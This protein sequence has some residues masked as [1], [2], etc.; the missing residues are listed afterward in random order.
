MTASTLILWTGVICTLAIFSLL[1]KENPVYRFFEHLF[2]GVATGYT[3]AQTWTDILKPKLWVG[4]V[5]DPAAGD[6]GGRWWMAVA[7]MI[8]LMYYAIYFRRFSWMSRLLIGIMMGFGAGLAFQG[9][10]TNYGP[11]VAA[12]FTPLLPGGQADLTL[13]KLLNNWVMFFT[14]VAVMTYFFFAFEQQN[15]AVQNTAKVGRWLLMISFGA[16]FG[17]TVM[18]RMALAAG[19]LGFLIDFFRHPMGGG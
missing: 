3:L 12:A 15:K 2:I 14:L 11:Q 19:R 5:G 4:L 1:Y 18:A 13:P 8:G 10:A 6:A 16:I 17:Q 7:A 9:F